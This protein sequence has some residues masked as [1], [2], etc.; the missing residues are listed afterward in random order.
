[1]DRA[2]CNRCRARGHYGRDCDAPL[3]KTAAC[4]HGEVTAAAAS[5]IEAEGEGRAPPSYHEDAAYDAALDPSHYAALLARYWAALSVLDTDPAVDAGPALHADSALDAERPASLIEAEGK[6]DR[7]PTPPLSDTDS[8]TAAVV[9][10]HFPS[11]GRL[12]GHCPLCPAAV[13]L[14]SDSEDEAPSRRARRAVR[15]SAPSTSRPPPPPSTSAKKRPPL[16]RSERR[17]SDIKS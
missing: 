10:L 7:T 3:V 13:L 1:M 4:W 15:L 16:R 9:C 5:V 8:T 17:V 2:I 6:G 14:E 12:C 11:I